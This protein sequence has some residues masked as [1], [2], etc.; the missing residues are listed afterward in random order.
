MAKESSEDAPFISILG[1]MGLVSQPIVWASLYSVATSGAGLPAG[2]LGLL[3]AVEGV[4][5]LVVVVLVARKLLLSDSSS[6][7]IKTAETLSLFSLGIS[8]LVVTNLVADQGCIPNAKPILDYSN[9]VP[10]C[11]P[12][13]TPG[14]F[15][16]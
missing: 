13:Q 9:Y 6:G 3:G 12:D 14:L 1:S 15:G 4:S 7:T 8:L 11:N 10:V 5:Y 16:N 2:P